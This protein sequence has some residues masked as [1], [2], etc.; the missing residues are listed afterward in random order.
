[1]INYAYN[2]V[3]I[4]KNYK[5]ITTSWFS[6]GLYKYTKPV[7]IIYNYNDIV[8]YLVR[9]NLNQFGMINQLYNCDI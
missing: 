8:T 1:M 9:M 4:L 2:I 3:N 7:N 6:Y 5:I